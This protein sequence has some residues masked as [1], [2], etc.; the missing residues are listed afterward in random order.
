MSTSGVSG[1]PLSPA[2]EGATAMRPETLTPQPS[3]AAERPV[4]LEL[5]RA[6]R[7]RP[8]LEVGV[9]VGVRFFLGIAGLLVVYMSLW[10]AAWA[11]LPAV[12]PGWRS[13]VISSGSMSPSIRRGDVVVAAPSD[14]QG[15]SP[16]VVIVISDP[17]ES[18]LV[19]HRI[20]G[21][22]PDGSYRTK[23]DANLDTD[24]T[25]VSP[26]HVIATGRLVIPYVGLP[27]TWYWRGAWLKLA[28]WGLGI[29]L[30][31]WAA[32]FAYQPRR[33]PSWHDDG[34]G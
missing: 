20:V 7:G 13:V 21:V 8:G 15:L 5:D 32:Q 18:G 27:H 9:A 11:V 22:N 31:V 28:L 2:V 23:G 1:L 16:G 30:S 25:P 26:E 34:A 17:A 29:A 10:L 3:V 4:S 12:V 14:G 19:T 33:Q 24:T 6:L